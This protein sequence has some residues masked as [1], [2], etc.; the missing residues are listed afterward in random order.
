M[1]QWSDGTIG[2]FSNHQAFSQ[3]PSCGSFWN[4]FHVAM[5]QCGGAAGDFVCEKTETSEKVYANPNDASKKRGIQFSKPSHISLNLTHVICPSGHWTHAFLA[6]DKR[7]DCWQRDTSELSG[8]TDAR[9]LS[10]PCRSSLSAMFTCRNGVEHVPYSL[11]CDHSQDC[12]DFS[13]EDFCV[14]PSCSGSWQFECNNG[15]V[16]KTTML[17]NFPRQ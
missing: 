17:R 5:Y 2:Y 9:S 13:D 10:S 12:L 16:R 15:Q 4:G 14:H 7:A 11:V 6:C 3:P 8:G 1:V